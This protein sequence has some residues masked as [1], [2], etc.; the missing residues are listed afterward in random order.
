MNPEPK[1][2][3]AAIGS[4][5]G[6]ALLTANTLW[7]GFLDLTDGGDAILHDVSNPA[8]YVN[9][10][11][12][13][14]AM[15]CIFLGMRGLN[16]VAMGGL[17][18]TGFYI[19]VIGQLLFGL[20][21]VMFLLI[22]LF[23]ITSL[24][25]TINPLTGISNLIM[26]LGALP[27]GLALCRTTIVSRTSSYLFLL[28]VPAVILSMTVVYN[29]NALLGGLLIGGVYGIAWILAGIGLSKQ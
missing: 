7:Q 13:I 8:Y 15:W 17:W 12:L 11:M 10:S 4:V 21:N 9:V 19:S 20:G 29:H 24:V 23:N 18:K 6:G 26:Y 16:F 3:Q 2:N 1:L 25:D 22:G 5:V 14:V 27:M 28:T